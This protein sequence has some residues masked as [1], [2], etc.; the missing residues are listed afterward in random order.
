[1]NRLQKIKYISLLT[2]SGIIFM[3]LFGAWKYTIS[4]AESVFQ[5]D[6][7]RIKQSFNQ[8][9][10][11]MEDISTAFYA[12][13]YLDQN[14]N[15]YK[16]GNFAT[17][18]MQKNLFLINVNFYDYV[19]KNQRQDFEKKLKKMA[20]G[21]DILEGGED[22]NSKIKTSEV[23][24]FYLPILFVNS[25][26]M[27]T[28]YFGWDI[29]SDKTKKDTID[30]V[31]KYKAIQASKTFL[32]ENGNVAVELFIPIYINESKS[33][34]RG[35]IGVTADLTQLLGD[36]QWSK[37]VE[38]TLTTILSGEKVEKDIFRRIDK[39][40]QNKLILSNLYTENYVDKFGQKFGLKFYRFLTLERINFG[41]ILITLLGCIIL[42]I[43]AVYLLITYQ[44][45][46]VSN[47]KLEDANQFLEERVKERTKELA[48]AHSEIKEILDNLEDGVLTVSP[49]LIIGRTY[50]PAALKILELT[51]LY[52]KDIKDILFSQLDKYNEENSRHL[53]TLGVLKYA[54]DFQW[55]LS[56]SDL[57]KLVNI[58]V[59]GKN[60]TLAL[61]YSPIFFNDQIQKIIFVISDI[62][63]I[64]ALRA[65]LAAKDEENSLKETILKEN[66][67]SK[68]ENLMTFYKENDPRVESFSIY[69]ETIK[70]ADASVM[71]R[72]LHTLKG[73]ARSVGLKLL[74][75]KVHILEDTLE[76]IRLSLVNKDKNSFT[77]NTQELINL[78]LLYKNY[79]E[80]Y[81]ELY[82]KSNGNNAEK[83]ALEILEKLL[84]NKVNTVENILKWM[85]DFRNKN[86]F[87]L[88]NLFFSFTDTLNEIAE[89]LG[90]KIELKL[91]EWDLYLDSK[92]SIPL[93]EAFTHSLRNALDHGIEDCNS[94]LEK[95]KNEAGILELKYEENNEAFLIQIVDDGRGVNTKKV[96]ELAFAK[97]LI[98]K[99]YEQCSE[100]EVIDLL[101]APGFST[102][103]EISELSGRGI[104]LDAV[105]NSCE[106]YNIKCSIISK[107]DL[108]SRFQLFIP[109]NYVKYSI[110]KDAK[111][112]MFKSA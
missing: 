104:G 14:M 110:S 98:S 36:E 40:I 54:D 81:K 22:E 21:N 6:T 11:A 44:K 100:D 24:E 63:E 20:I 76:P 87:S 86:F 53:F 1:M 61:K 95:N 78:N 67:Y 66:I 23:R 58:E 96:Y 34:L 57:L 75:K 25:G 37:Q 13:S 94:R 65:S 18:I 73:S 31:I 28:T 103:E 71:L 60:K 70:D 80:I 52:Q 5:T 10:K 32:L 15:Q 72:D 85:E 41:I 16:F 108:G 7:I 74:A 106:K 59:N 79:R 69:K 38:I 39:D 17:E 51:E 12:F 4:V 49:D 107:T 19:K 83:N 109:K 105:R 9:I 29:N 46:E 93:S 88:K 33:E 43:L 84:L 99:T 55:S 89:N 101:F 82:E 112:V 2:L 111:L 30:Y 27:K 26:A 91:P 8:G 68:P 62:T 77:I 47:Y 56:S 3:I 48:L 97:K 102:K 90:K 42:Y 45:L 35:I 92:I 64:L 50:S